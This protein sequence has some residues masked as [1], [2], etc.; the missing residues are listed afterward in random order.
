MKSMKP[1]Y[2]RSL[3]AEAEKRLS[4]RCQFEDRSDRGGHTIDGA[5]PE[6]VKRY[7]CLVRG[8]AFVEDAQDDVPREV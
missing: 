4:G 5:E 2:L 6:V 8:R 7:S 3:D 1:Q